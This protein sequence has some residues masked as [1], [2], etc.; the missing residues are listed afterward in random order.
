MQNIAPAQY[1]SR[2]SQDLL[3]LHAMGISG[4]SATGAM[5]EWQEFCPILRHVLNLCLCGTSDKMTKCLRGM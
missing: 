1:R 5:V 4:T 3:D 2:A